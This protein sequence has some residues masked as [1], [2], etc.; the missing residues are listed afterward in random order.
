MILINN[1]KKVLSQKKKLV[2]SKERRINY[3]KTIS[4]I[5]SKKSKI[6]ENKINELKLT[7]NNTNYI[8]RMNYK[9]PVINNKK[10]EL[11]FYK[12]LKKSNINPNLKRKIEILKEN[13]YNIDQLKKRF[14]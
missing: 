9:V 13:N 4:H 5:K 6:N 1:R 7:K 12:L 8:K 2:E 10:L 3:S 14:Y 11:T